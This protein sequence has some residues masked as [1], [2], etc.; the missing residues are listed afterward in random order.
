MS[1]VRVYKVLTRI[2]EWAPASIIAQQ[3]GLPLP[4][5]RLALRQLAAA[6]RAKRDVVGKWGN[7]GGLEEHWA[8]KGFHEELPPELTLHKN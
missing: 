8:A 6:D 5:V 7:R 1:I 4:A 2:R 3:S